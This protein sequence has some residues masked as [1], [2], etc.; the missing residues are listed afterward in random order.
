MKP[1]CV[2]CDTEME[3]GFLVDHGYAMIFPAAWGAGVPKW[4][5]WSGL[6]LA[7]KD[8]IPVGAFRCPTCNRI[9]LFALPG[10]WPA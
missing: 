6:K 5:R 9:E 3:Q 1:T 10:T 2:R 4:S 7:R 8:K